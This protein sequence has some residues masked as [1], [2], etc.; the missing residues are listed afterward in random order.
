MII[1]YTEL[2]AINANKVLQ[3]IC[4]LNKNTKPIKRETLMKKLNV[5]DYRYLKVLL[6]NAR[7]RGTPICN[8]MDGKGY[9]IGGANEIEKRLKVL[10]K[11][12]SGYNK[13][14]KSLKRVLING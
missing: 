6:H 2:H 9:Y 1:T 4:L 5:S 11:L 12:V 10:R 13:E 7:L 3:L 14:I 8:D